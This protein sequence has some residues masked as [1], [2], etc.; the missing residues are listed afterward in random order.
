MAL[1]A[2]H[3]H[4]ELQAE[5]ALRE[6]LVVKANSLMSKVNS[7]RL[8]APSD[9]VLISRMTQNLAGSFISEGQSIGMVVDPSKIEINASIPQYA[10]EAVAHNV[11]AP[12]SVSMYNGERWK[13][14]ILKTLPRTSDTLASP[15]LA[16]IYGGP[17]TVV[18]NN[19]PNG[20]SVLKTDKPR[21][22]TRI[23]LTEPAPSSNRFFI[24]SHNVPP[25]PGALCSV[26]LEFQNEAV[27]QTGFRWIQ[28]GF[29]TQFQVTK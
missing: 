29:Q 21:L 19:A 17:I 3:K 13:G 5:E 20:E 11:D 28:A 16:G 4:S 6:S 23:E 7:L 18:R 10:W 1:R 26:K 2:Q 14:M 22:H 15:S 12:V 9:G 25:P 27:W 8:R 24:A